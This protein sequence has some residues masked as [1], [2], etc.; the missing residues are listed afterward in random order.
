MKNIIEIYT[1]WP[2]YQKKLDYKDV[3]YYKTIFECAKKRKGIIINSMLLEAYSKNNHYKHENNIILDSIS[4]IPFL[5][6]FDMFEL[7]S[8]VLCEYIKKKDL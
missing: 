7:Q 3:I 5:I 1:D 2:E 6:D 4:S 8:R